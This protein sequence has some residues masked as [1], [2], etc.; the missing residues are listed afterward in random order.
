MK[1]VYKNTAPAQTALWTDAEAG[2]FLGG[3]PPR[4]LRLWRHRR[5]LPFIRITSK[6]LRYRQADIE[7]WLDARS[8]MIRG[9]R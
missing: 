5:S 7:K 4:T 9:A 2:A 1:P 8:V 3:I 6:V